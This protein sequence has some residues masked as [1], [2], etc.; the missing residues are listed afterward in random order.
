MEEKNRFKYSISFPREMGEWFEKLLPN[1]KG[2]PS[3]CVQAF[4]KPAFDIWHA[5]R[6]KDIGIFIPP[7][8]AVA[9]RSAGY[10]NKDKN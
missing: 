3:T 4:M 1:F 2:S 9:E 6:M 10:N 5:Q 8:S 7:A